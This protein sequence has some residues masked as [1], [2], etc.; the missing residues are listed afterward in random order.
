MCGG[1]VN[2]AARN[3]YGAAADGIVTLRNFSSLGEDLSAYPHYL[4]PG[5]ARTEMTGGLRQ[6]YPHLVMTAENAS[7]LA[8]FQEMSNHY[9]K[10]LRST[11]DGLS[12]DI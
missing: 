9:P 10:S 7:A 11:R 3:R 8:W 2:E 4:L 5:N 12:F 6:V 1:A